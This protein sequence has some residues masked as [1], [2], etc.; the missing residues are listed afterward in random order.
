VER[1]SGHRKR[2]KG[3]ESR[4]TLTINGRVSVKRTRWHSAAE[5][6]ETPIDAFLDAAEASVSRGARELCCL[7]NA[8]AASFERAAENLRRSAGLRLGSELL[9]QVVEA[10]GR[11]V[12]A[13]RAS[14]ALSPTWSGSGPGG[15]APRRLYLGC[16]GFIA[17]LVTDSEKKKR[18]LRVRQKQRSRPKQRGSKDA[19]RRRE[20]AKRG[21]DQAFKE[22]KLVTFYDDAGEHRLVSL[23]REDHHAAGR[24]MRRDGSQCGFFQAEQK[25]AVVDGGPWIANQIKRQSLPVTA[26]CL[27]F[28][29]LAEN[30]HKARRCC[31]GEEDPAGYDWA[32][33]ILHVAK[34]QGYEALRERLIR[35]RGSLRSK[36]RRRAAELLIRY[37]TDRREMIDYPRFLK[38]G[39]QIGSGPTESQCKQVPRRVKG[40]GKR[41]DADNAE[42]V[43]ALEAMRQSHLHERYWKQCA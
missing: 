6:A 29:H 25:L 3:V 39:W 13:C 26:V 36:S 17:R 34:H 2:R 4:S 35:W 42:A 21:A 41:W 23:T 38:E 20:R 19:A 16:D 1:S 40:R 8:D 22:F 9:R 37:V 31:F 12:L 10:E 30:V 33:M 28:F 5:G 15:P 27:D 32:G 18:R 43:M 7:L 11:H 24:L 14:G